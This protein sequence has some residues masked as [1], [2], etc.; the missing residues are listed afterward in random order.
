[1]DS[2]TPHH[3]FLT[4][5][6]SIKMSD[7]VSLPPQMISFSSSEYFKIAKVYSPKKFTNSNFCRWSR[8]KHRFCLLSFLSHLKVFYFLNASSFSH[9]RFYKELGSIKE[10]RFLNLSKVIRKVLERFI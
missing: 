8:F 5:T 9:E 2:K 6:K 10:L 4:I 7:R 1:M 3:H